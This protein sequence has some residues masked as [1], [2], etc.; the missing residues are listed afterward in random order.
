MVTSADLSPERAARHRRCSEKDPRNRLL[1]RGPQ[2]RLT[3][4]MVRDQAL[5]ASGLLNAA[6]GRAAGDAGSSPMASGM[7]WPTIRNAGPTPPGRPLSPRGLYLHQAH[8][9]LSQLRH[10]R[11]GG[12]PADQPAPHS[13]QYAVAGAGDPERS[14]LSTRRPMRW[15]ARMI[16]RERQ[17]HDAMS[18]LELWRPPGAVARSDAGGIGAA[19]QAL[20]GAAGAGRRWRSALFNLDAA[21]TR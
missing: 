19:A 11:C 3:A 18:R 14:G 6:D 2:Q 5:L 17:G 8:R 16:K 15:P 12:P 9:D 7:W 20:S 10:L 4:E 1:A 21:L 13:H